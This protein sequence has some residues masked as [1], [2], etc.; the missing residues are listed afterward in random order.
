MGRCRP[1][2]RSD[3]QVHLVAT[4]VD[5]KGFLAVN[6]MARKGA[7]GKAAPRRLLDHV[8]DLH[9]FHHSEAKQVRRDCQPLAGRH[10]NS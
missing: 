1:G 4:A 5:V 2:K 6:G 8:D 10:R 9:G 7:V 3:G